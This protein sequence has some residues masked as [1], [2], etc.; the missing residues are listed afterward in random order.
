MDFRTVD[1]IFTSETEWDDI[2]K[3]IPT[4]TGYGVLWEQ[5]DVSC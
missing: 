4:I 3:L 1:D 2:S 5:I